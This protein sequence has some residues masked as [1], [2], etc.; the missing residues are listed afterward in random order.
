VSINIWTVTSTLLRYGCK[1]LW[2]GCLSI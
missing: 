2:C 1:V